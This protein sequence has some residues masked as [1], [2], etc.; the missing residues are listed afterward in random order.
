MAR[1]V[2][3]RWLAVVSLMLA[4]HAHARAED[5]MLDL[6]AL[7]KG[8]EGS[9]VWRTQKSWMVKYTNART[10]IHP[11]P[12]A[13]VEWPDAEVVNAR[14]GDWLF[15]HV[16]QPTAQRPDT[17]LD[18]WLL[19]R[20]GK[21][22]DRIGGSVQTGNDPKQMASYFWYPNSLMRDGLV[23]LLKVPKVAYFLD[24]EL[25]RVL[26]WCLQANKA[27]YQV[28]K[29]LEDI[30]G[31]MCHVVERPGHDVLW[32]DAKHGFQVRRRT[33]LQKSGQP[34]SEFRATDFRERAPGVWLPTRQI[35]VAYN[36]DSDPPEYRG[37][38]RFV[39][40]NTL[41]EARFGELPDDVFAVPEP[42][43]R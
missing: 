36:F 29:E 39:M 21:F 3:H 43:K 22:T 42:K 34:L 26:P 31:A 1:T 19:W 27:G 12:K 5:A 37:R 4:V 25:S 41:S 32:I 24:P 8:I 10:R 13:M 2:W 20:D 38:L 40:T 18:H 14:K 28:R 16:R 7:I 6:D 9:D 30:D 15:A 17:I 11:P 23:G 33:L 35:A